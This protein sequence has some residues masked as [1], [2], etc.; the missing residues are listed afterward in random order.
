MNG[1]DRGD[2]CGAV[3]NH[4]D[5]SGDDRRE[6]G[7]VEDKGKTLRTNGTLWMS[8]SVVIGVVILASLGGWA[9]KRFVVYWAAIESEYFNPAY[10]LNKSNYT[11]VVTHA[12][13]GF[14]SLISTPLVLWFHLTRPLSCLDITFEVIYGCIV[15]LVFA[16]VIPL[17]SIQILGTKAGTSIAVVAML[18]VCAMVA[19]GVVCGLMLCLKKY[20]HHRGF[21]LRFMGLVCYGSLLLPVFYAFVDNQYLNLALLLVLLFFTIALSELTVVVVERIRPLPIE[22]RKVSGSRPPSKVDDSMERLPDGGN[23]QPCVDV[24]GQAGCRGA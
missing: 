21:L 12:S 4:V 1:D 8:I 13:F 5:A 18:W 9:M 20:R 2:Q 22:K 15:I 3:A 23:T 11:A 14:I 7:V 24:E 16:T 10:G 19:E 6:S 17:G